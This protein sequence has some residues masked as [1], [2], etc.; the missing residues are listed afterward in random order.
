MQWERGIVSMRSVAIVNQELR[1][2]L[3]EKVTFE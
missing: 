2:G 3:I 1:A